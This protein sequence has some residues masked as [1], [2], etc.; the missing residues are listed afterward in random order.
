MKRVS[1]PWAKLQRAAALRT[2]RERKSKPIPSRDGILL[3]EDGLVLIVKPE[4]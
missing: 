2:L 1:L 4:V 3:D